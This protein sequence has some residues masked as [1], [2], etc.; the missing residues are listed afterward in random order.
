MNDFNCAL[1][2]LDPLD[3][4]FLFVVVFF[5]LYVFLAIFIPPQ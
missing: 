3:P 4:T 2:G 1:D 5:L